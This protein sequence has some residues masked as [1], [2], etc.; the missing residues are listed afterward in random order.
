M[1][2]YLSRLLD[3]VDREDKVS[4]LDRIVVIKNMF[5]PSD[6]DVRNDTMPCSVNFVRIL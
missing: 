5:D 1:S 3:W 6:F 2:C 4:K